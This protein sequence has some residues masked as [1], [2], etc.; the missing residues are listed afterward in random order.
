MEQLKNNFK[1]DYELSVNSFNS[2]DYTSFF[3]NIRPAIEWLCKLVIYDALG[4]KKGLSLINGS[5]SICWRKDI[6]IYQ[7]SECPPQR[8]PS[9]REFC[10]LA[11]QSFYCQNTD[12]TSSRCDERKK[13]LKRGLDSYAAEFSRYYSIASELGHH[14]GDTDMQLNIQAISCASF[15]ESYYDFLNSHKVLGN[16]TI[17]FLQGLKKFTY[18]DPTMLESAKARIESLISELEEKESALLIAQKLQAEAEQHRL[19]AESRT[20]EVESQLIAC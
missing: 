17:S 10:D 4:V 18:E 11:V 16:S 7:I 12:V 1:R 6:R 5:L 19:E 9:G 15:F 8:N 14:T 2:K 3:R 20:S 13:R